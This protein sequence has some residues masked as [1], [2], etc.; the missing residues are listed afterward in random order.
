M[1]EKKAKNEVKVKKSAV[2]YVGP[3]IPNL[4]QNS[5]TFKNGML[6][7]ALEKCVKEKPYMQKLFVAIEELP[8]AVKELN[9]NK[10]ALSAIC[11]KVKNEF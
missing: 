7:E 5:T 11:R 6:P 9:D 1:S 10:S 3:T 2:M 8:A 4:V